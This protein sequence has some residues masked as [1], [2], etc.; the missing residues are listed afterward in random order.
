[1]TVTQNLGLSVHFYHCCLFHCKIVPTVIT[2]PSFICAKYLKRARKWNK[3]FTRFFKK[4][5]KSA[6]KLSTF[7]QQNNFE[8]NKQS[9]KKR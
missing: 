6:E 1:M 4:N 8:T 2:L 5:R 3:S 7:K 9:Y